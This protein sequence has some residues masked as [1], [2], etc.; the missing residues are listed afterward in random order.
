MSK[1]NDLSSAYKL[2]QKHV[3]SLYPA[4]DGGGFSD[5][6]MLDSYVDGY[7][8]IAP[9]LDRAMNILKDRVFCMC[10]VGGTLCPKCEL[11]KDINL[12]LKD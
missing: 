1:T 6:Q 9:L 10:Q 12:K 8:K 11:I 7:Q 3:D 4:L 5:T 2:A